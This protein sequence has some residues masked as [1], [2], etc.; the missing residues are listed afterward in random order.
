MVIYVINSVVLIQLLWKAWRRTVTSMS[1][2]VCSDTSLVCVLSSQQAETQNVAHESF[3]IPEWSLRCFLCV[4]KGPERVFPQCVRAGPGLQLL[5]GK[6]T[7][8]SSFVHL[9][10]TYFTNASTRK[11]KQKDKSTEFPSYLF[12]TWMNSPGLKIQLNEHFQ[13][14]IVPLFRTFCYG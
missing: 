12:K 8:K 7:W 6:S 3:P 11:Y 2:T 4:L 14:S 1:L 9:L 13:T 10:L 5:Q